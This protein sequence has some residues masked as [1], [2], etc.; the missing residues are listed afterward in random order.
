MSSDWEGQCVYL[1]VFLGP[2]GL[3]S[4]KN[5]VPTIHNGLWQRTSKK[6][7]CSAVRS[8]AVCV[9]QNI[10]KALGIWAQHQR[11]GEELR[12]SR[13]DQSGADAPIHLK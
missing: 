12:H 8:P 9:H 11:Q 3:I 1:P 5:S 6:N 10:I 4:D 7:D 2:R 13:G